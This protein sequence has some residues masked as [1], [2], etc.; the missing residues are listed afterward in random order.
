[1]SENKTCVADWLLAE[2]EMAVENT[3]MLP[4]TSWCNFVCSLVCR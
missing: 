4:A 1:M 3:T 2:N